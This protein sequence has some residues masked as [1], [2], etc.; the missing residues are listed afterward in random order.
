[1]G[2]GGGKDQGELR[3]Q[4]GSKASK[5]EQTGSE[6]NKGCKGISI[7]GFRVPTTCGGKN[8]NDHI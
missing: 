8:F 5:G 2:Q 7:L 1:M 3:E 6:G 4:T